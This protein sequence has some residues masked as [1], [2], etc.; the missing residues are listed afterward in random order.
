MYLRNGYGLGFNAYKNRK[1]LQ[2]SKGYQ[3]GHLLMVHNGIN[4]GRAGCGEDFHRKA[5]RL[6][7]EMMPESRLCQT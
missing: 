5:T 2:N 1:G 4:N 3:A 7:R 6:M